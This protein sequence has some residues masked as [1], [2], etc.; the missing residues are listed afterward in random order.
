[1][2]FAGIA[3]S[4]AGDDYHVSVSL[5][6]SRDGS[7]IGSRSSPVRISISSLAKTIESLFSQIKNVKVK[8]YAYTLSPCLAADRVYEVDKATEVLKETIGANPRPTS[9]FGEAYAVGHLVKNSRNDLLFV[10]FV[11]PTEFSA[12][13]VQGTI[14]GG[15]RQWKLLHQAKVSLGDASVSPASAQK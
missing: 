4:P 10:D 6:S 7:I 12:C 13:F 2:A 11:S 8:K 5:V 15:R 14:E 9:L 3:I 1:M